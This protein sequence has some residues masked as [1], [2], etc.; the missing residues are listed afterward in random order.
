MAP[1]P[2]RG[3]S[4]WGYRVIGWVRPVTQIG[5][6]T[7]EGDDIPSRIPLEWGAV[8]GESPVDKRGH[9]PVR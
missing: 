3:Y 1:R 6:H 4:T 8:G 9:T 7:R 2:G 5:A